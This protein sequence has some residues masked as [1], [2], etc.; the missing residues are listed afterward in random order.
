MYSIR[1]TRLYTRMSGIY[2]AGILA[3]VPS[4]STSTTSSSSTTSASSTSWL[5]AKCCY[6]RSS[7]LCSHTIGTTVSIG[8][9]LAL[10][11]FT[12]KRIKKV[13][14]L[15]H[16]LARWDSIFGFCSDLLLIKFSQTLLEVELFIWNR[17]WLG[18]LMSVRSSSPASNSIASASSPAWLAS[19]PGGLCTTSTTPSSPWYCWFD[20]CWV[21]SSGCVCIT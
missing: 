2:F 17:Q 20:C 18:R 1:M 14:L 6:I 15:I 13:I 8:V 10:Q 4:S 9:I 21:T 7:L 12:G 5:V 19:S 11:C 3:V 16:F